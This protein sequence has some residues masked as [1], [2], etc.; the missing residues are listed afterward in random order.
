MKKTTKKKT[1]GPPPLTQLEMERE[2]ARRRLKRSLARAKEVR[3]LI[4]RVTAENGRR[5]VELMAM[6]RYFMR[7]FGIN[8][9]EPLGPPSTE[10]APK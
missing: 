10:D 5:D 2:E 6:T 9:A 7:Y 1:A 3:M 4:R 8:E